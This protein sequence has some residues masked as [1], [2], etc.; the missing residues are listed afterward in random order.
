MHLI[1]YEDLLASPATAFR[2][3]LTFL[4]WGTAR[5]RIEHAVEQTR[6][7]RLARREADDGFAERSDKSGSGRFFRHGRAGRWN[8]VLSPPQ[9]DTVCREHGAVMRRVGYEVRPGVAADIVD[10]VNVGA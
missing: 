3:V 5:K 1:R 6:I 8:D 4:G 7:A 10:T 9:V 2:N